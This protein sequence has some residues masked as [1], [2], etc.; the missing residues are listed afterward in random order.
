MIA[1]GG[2]RG[3][4]THVR[5]CGLMLGMPCEPITT[6]AALARDP[7]PW[8]VGYLLSYQVSSGAP[9]ATERRLYLLC[10][11]YT[12]IYIMFVTGDQARNSNRGTCTGTG[13]QNTPFGSMDTDPLV[14]N[15]YIHIVTLWIGFGPEYICILLFLGVPKGIIVWHYTVVLFE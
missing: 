6:S 4:L 5:S 8:L 10:I 3:M 2:M 15:I 9:G 7:L 13:T 11:P 14:W 1:M 12:Y